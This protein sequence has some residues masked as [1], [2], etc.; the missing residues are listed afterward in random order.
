MADKM[1]GRGRLVNLTHRTRPGALTVPNV[2]GMRNNLLQPSRTVW[3]CLALTMACSDAPSLQRLAPPE[4]PAT[5]SG[6][7][8][9]VEG[10]MVK[11]RPHTAPGPMR[12]LELIAA[13]NEF[14]SFQVALHG[15]QTGVTVASL[16]LPFLRGPDI[17]GGKD[18]TLYRQTFLDITHPTTLDSQPGPWPDGLIPDVDEL[19]GER[20]LAFP[21]TVPAGEARAI[22]VDVH[23]PADAR[24]GSYEGRAQVM[25][26]D[27]AHVDLRIRLRVIDTLM[28]ST[29][30]LQTAFF[31]EPRSIC[32]AFTGNECSSEDVLLQLLPLFYRLGLE[33]RVTLAGGFPPVT[34][35]PAWGLK[36]WHTFERLWGPFLNGTTLSRLPG[37]RLTTW[38]YLGPSNAESLLE[39]TKET[40]IRGWLPRA[41]DYVGDEPPY[42]STFEDIRQRATAVR[43][44]APELRILLT[45][46]IDSLA[47][48]DLEELVDIIVVLVNL[49]GEPVPGGGTQRPRYDGFLAR[50]QR[51]LWL[52][53]SCASHGCGTPMREN[54]PG[55]GWPSYMIDRPATKN[56]AMQWVAFLQDATG[57][58]YYQTLEMFST[59]WTDQ[60]RYW[61]NGDGTL[62]YPGL[63]SIIG[64]TTQVP[65][66]SLRLKLIRLGL[67]DYE[68]LKAVS[69]A[70]DPEYAR[71]I[72]LRVVPT[73]WRVP[74]DGVLFE[75]AR[76]CLIRRY[77]QLTAFKNPDEV[78]RFIEVP[79]PEGFEVPPKG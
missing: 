70:G 57:E 19:T 77:M 10:P 78:I 69:E 22:W 49:I 7:P 79:C 30:S 18:I 63:P 47:R 41:F 71:R 76:L 54:T 14:V 65:I 11:I 74:D 50:P 3:L 5:W 31:V 61:G 25:T 23:V 2:A 34:V 56:R 44:S 24:P 13:R 21:F 42:W 28:P 53:Q 73:P 38:R 66:P 8:V 20:R 40:H 29:S 60:F 68:W 58:L 4:E 43:K 46:E 6:P 26:S 17:I 62:F 16:S 67:Q 59:A 9:W 64:G 55:Q 39:F 35:Q 27:G 1:Q 45:S 72:A 48:E 32:Y 51:E 15:G 37:A 36:D 75:T 12:E 33:H 52:Y